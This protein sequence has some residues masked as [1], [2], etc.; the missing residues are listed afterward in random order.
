MR[1]FK[2]SEQH[3]PCFYMH[4]VGQRRRSLRPDEAATRVQAWLRGVN[5]RQTLGAKVSPAFV[6]SVVVRF[7]NLAKAL[8]HVLSM[9]FQY[10]WLCDV[11]GSVLL[12]CPSTATN[13]R[14]F[15]SRE[16]LQGR[17]QNDSSA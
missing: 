3:R 14:S 16:P 9:K 4:C 10:S 17:K 1:R 13:R 6:E 11:S 8:F 15:S 2:N 12:P 5:C 7:S